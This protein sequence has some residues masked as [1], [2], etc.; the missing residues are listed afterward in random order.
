MQ[1]IANFAAS[2]AMLATKYS[3]ILLKKLFQFA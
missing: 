3:D 2:K 1:T